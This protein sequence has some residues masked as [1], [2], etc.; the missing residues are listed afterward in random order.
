[1]N[2][3]VKHTKPALQSVHSVKWS[4][5][6]GVRPH[7][8]AS[9]MCNVISGGQAYSSVWCDRGS[10]LQG[11]GVS[12]LS[13]ISQIRVIHLLC[14]SVRARPAPLIVALIHFTQSQSLCARFSS[15]YVFS[16]ENGFILINWRAD[17]HTSFQY[18]VKNVENC[19]TSSFSKCAWSTRYADRRHAQVVIS[20]GFFNLS[21]CS[22]QISWERYKPFV[23]SPHRSKYFFDIT[24]EEW[25]AVCYFCRFESTAH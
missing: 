10:V 21:H 11:L 25:A 12:M 3:N 13:V 8:C 22:L 9:C 17:N 15:F 5:C 20:G 18:G 19:V 4:V 2:F 14:V 16:N 7:A 6:V 24:D 1:M 23:C